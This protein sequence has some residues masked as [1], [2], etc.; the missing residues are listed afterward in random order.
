MFIICGLGNPGKKYA[1]NRHN[2]G[3][4]FV[5]YLNERYLQGTFKK[6]FNFY[7]LKGEIHGVEVLLV[8][9]DTFM[10]LSGQ[11][12]SSAMGYF[13]VAL[14]DVL[15]V[16]DDTAIPFGMLRIREKGSPGGHNGLKNIEAQ[17][18]SAAYARVRVG[19]DAPQFSTHLVA[20]VL[21]DFD[22]EELKVLHDEV[23][24]KL[25]KACGL[26]VKGKLKDAMNRYNERIGK[27]EKKAKKEEARKEMEAQQGKAEE[28]SANVESGNDGQDQGEL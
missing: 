25:D 19:V 17:L 12:L 14:E 21:G 2:A 8:K 7:Y 1:K 9:P 27:K 28:P 15:V 18:G 11:A 24:N 23:F 16:Y 20:H 3:F 26:I 4:L 5:D 6:K 13:K 22:N 10:N